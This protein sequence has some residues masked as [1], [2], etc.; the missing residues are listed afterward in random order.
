MS[1][2]RRKSDREKTPDTGLTTALTAGAAVAGVAAIAYGA[3]RL[4]DY[5]ASSSAEAAEAQSTAG[6]KACSSSDEDEAPSS[7][8]G[9]RRRTGG[10]P[11]TSALPP[12]RGSMGSAGSQSAYAASSSQS[13]YVASSS[14]VSKKEFSLSDR[15]MQYYRGHV[16][17]SP[18]DMREVSKVVKD[19]KMRI[20]SHLCRS[21]KLVNLNVSKPE[22]FGS[23]VDGLMVVF[24]RQFNVLIPFDLCPDEFHIVPH[25]DVT[26]CHSVAVPDDN[27][28]WMAL[29]NDEHCLDPSHFIALLS[30][31]LEEA[32]RASCGGNL[33]LTLQKASAVMEGRTRQ[34]QKFTIHVVPALRVGQRCFTAE[35]H[36]GAECKTLYWRE[37]FFDQE[38]NALSRFGSFV[39]GHKVILKIFKTIHLNFPLQFGLLTSYHYKTILLRIMDDQAAAEDW[40]VSHISER[41]ID[42]LIELGH[43]LKEKN[44]PHY[45]QGGRNLFDQ[46]SPEQLQ[47]LAHFIN[48]IVGHHNIES[49][50]KFDYV[51]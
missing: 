18:S 23:S 44:L 5:F 24:P 42:F 26:D 28:S 31:V 14:H 11:S 12:S 36:L 1:Q 51:Q 50:L 19:V 13:A 3:W 39:I 29:C 45:F 48:R 27:S 7:S 4:Y 49:L 41:F 20:A 43:C 22:E 34:L 2:R 8:G 32:V 38:L 6:K 25:C 15:L 47:S 9:A 10:Y 16:D 37:L 21:E 40:D 17:V 35:M 46:I 30:G 33:K